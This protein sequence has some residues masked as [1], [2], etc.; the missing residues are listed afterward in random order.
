MSGLEP[1]LVLQEFCVSK[2]EVALLD[3][4]Y[5][6]I[7]SDYQDLRRASFLQFGSHTFEKDHP[8]TFQQQ[9]NGEPYA[10]GVLFHASKTKE[11]NY[12]EYFSD[13]TEN[14]GFSM[15][16]TFR[17]RRNWLNELDHLE[18]KPHP[19]APTYKIPEIIE[20]NHIDDDPLDDNYEYEEHD[21]PFEETSPIIENPFIR[22]IDHSTVIEVPEKVNS[23][24]EGSIYPEIAIDDGSFV[25]GEIETS[26]IP[27][28]PGS[29]PASPHIIPDQQQQLESDP[30]LE[31]QDL[32]EAAYGSYPEQITSSKR[33]NSSDFTKGG[34]ARPRRHSV[35]EE[36]PKRPGKKRDATL[37]YHDLT[38]SVYRAKWARYGEEYKPDKKWLDE[39][40][41][42]YERISVDRETVMYSVRPLSQFLDIAS[43]IFTRKRPEPIRPRASG[44]RNGRVSSKPH[45]GSSKDKPKEPKKPIIMVPPNMTEMITI[46]NSSEFFSKGQYCDSM[47]ARTP[48]LKP[49]FVEFEYEDKKYQVTDLAD[50]LKPEDWDRVVAVIV[51]GKDWQFKNW[52]WQSTEDIFKNVK[53]FH[54]KWSHMETDKN[55]L[56]WGK[57]VEII[58]ISRDFRHKDFEAQNAF[59]KALYSHIYK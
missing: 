45:Q 48:G 27:K 10:L 41:T 19:V 8:T 40:M 6:H 21:S 58:N 3:H 5:D 20:R 49:T 29:Q 50:N 57:A 17:D 44:D 2:K 22:Q 55:V 14:A 11:L 54:F 9:S 28:Y 12:D 34:K 18:S 36:D 15:P 47:K 42:P 33:Q 13:A 38:K 53:A 46:Y 37:M 32:K 1:I 7:S 35:T 30:F 56:R 51:T 31:E 25:V 39:N 24:F 23:S 43:D 59:W 26:S 52:K 16:L 4:E